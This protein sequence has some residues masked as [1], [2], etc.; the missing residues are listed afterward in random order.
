MKLSDSKKQVTD[1]NND[2]HI[3][4]TDSEESLNL[5]IKPC[6]TSDDPE[7]IRSYIEKENPKF[8]DLEQ[9]VTSIQLT[10]ALK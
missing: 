4:A 1:K 6:Q 10:Q 9:N 2:F 3:L 7:S 8:L 5:V